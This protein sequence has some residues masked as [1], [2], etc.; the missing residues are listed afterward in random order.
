M[1]ATDGSDAI[2]MML[3]TLRWAQGARREEAAVSEFVEVWDRI[4]FDE[5]GEA[6]RW[7]R[8]LNK[9]QSWLEIDCSIFGGKPPFIKM[10]P[11]NSIGWIEQRFPAREG[12]KP[13]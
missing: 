6:T 3:P 8:S 1:M 2:A 11:D 13:Q 4:Y 12:R 5:K 9:G 10:N 7:E